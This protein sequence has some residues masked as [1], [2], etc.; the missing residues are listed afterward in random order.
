MAAAA[1]A[2]LSEPT[3]PATPN[4][5]PAIDGFAEGS[6]EEAAFFAAY[7]EVEIDPLVMAY[8]RYER[9]TSDLG[10]FA[11]RVYWMP[12]ADGEARRADARWVKVLFEPDQTVEMAYRAEAR[13]PS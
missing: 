4:T 12:D 2:A 8:Y 5:G 13:L 7:G 10:A 9:V 6:A 11:Y 1:P 3:L